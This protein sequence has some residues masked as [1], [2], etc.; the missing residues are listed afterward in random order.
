MPQKRRMGCVVYI[1]MKEGMVQMAEKQ[2]RQ[3]GK[4][5]RVNK[6]VLTIVTIIDMF[7]FFGYIGDYA[8]GNISFGFM[9]AVDLSVVI[10]MIACYAVYFHKKD[11]MA[12]QHVSVVG[13][14]VVYGLAVFGAQNDLVFMMVFPLTVIYILYYDFKLILR[15]AV[16]FGAINVVDVFYIAVVLG[17]M[18]SGAPLNSTSLLLQGASAVVYMIVLCGTTQISNDNN[19]KKIENINQEKEK[20]TAL[21]NE[22][23]RVVASVRQDSTEAAEHIRQLSQDVDSTVSELGGIAEGN[24]T[25]AESIEKQT[26]MTGNI[27]SMILETKQMSDEMLAM[28]ESSENAVQEGQQ[29][30]D[31][32]QSQAHRTEEANEQVVSSVSSLIENAKAV[33]NITEQIFSISSQTN[34][35]ALNASIESARAG[36]AGKGFAVVS[37]EIRA[38]ADETRNLTEGIRKIVDELKRN[39]D[40]AK[41]TVDNVMMAAGTEHELIANASAQFG[42]IGSRMGGLHTNVSEIYKKIEE[43]LE[44]NNV[45]VD[46]INH[47]SAVS[48]E[49][50]A[51]TQQ[52]AELGADTSRK[53]EQ[54]RGLMMGLL[55]TVKAIDKYL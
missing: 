55:E 10:S 31:R 33:E 8:Q 37:E 38:L 36:A 43:I 18:H 48:E 32:L 46:S 6:F 21:L 20:S 4:E 12:F 34:L 51:S 30:V 47:I 15:I 14:M 3:Y 11:S 44:A 28:A 50:T 2:Y 9:L 17:H 27:Q 35:L 5:K 22:V 49:V 45:I 16:I 52:A 53:A 7:L 19:A 42:E 13:Y 54:A 1:K 25:N 23:L 26:M 39:A 29:T 40:T 24:S 41:N